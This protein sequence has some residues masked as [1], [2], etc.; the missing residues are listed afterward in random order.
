MSATEIREWLASLSRDELLDEAAW[1]REF[2]NR[3]AEHCGTKDCPSLVAYVNKL[4]DENARLRDLVE[5]LYECPKG[6]KCDEC[7]GLN[8]GFACA[9]IMRELGF[10]VD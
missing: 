9:Y 4:R 3:M 8:D 6:P 1:T 10:E 7:M 5:M 2:L